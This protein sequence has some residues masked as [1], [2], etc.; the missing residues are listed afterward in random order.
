MRPEFSRASIAQRL[1]R[2]CLVVPADPGTQ[3]A[4][5]VLE[6]EE[7]VLPDTFLLHGAEEP[8]DDPVLLRR[9]GGCS[10]PSESSHLRCFMRPEFSRASIA[11]R[12][13]RACLVVPADPGTQLAP[14]VLEAEEVVLPDTF[15]LHGAEEPLDDPVLLRRVGGDELLGEP[16]VP[17]RRSA[18][19]TMACSIIVGAD[20]RRGPHRAQRAEPVQ[21][22]LLER[23]LSLL[24]PAP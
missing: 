9:V 2:A 16:I 13:V 24:G 10:A 12:L 20:N 5:S 1:V 6:A 11:Q 17:P 18:A 19:P 15:L 21:A 22:R 8:L 14:S 4:P 3:L 23:P 7:V